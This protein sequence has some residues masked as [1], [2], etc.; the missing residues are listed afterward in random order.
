MRRP[1]AIA[2]VATRS[3]LYGAV[4][5]GL[6]AYLGMT[7]LPVF[8][9]VTAAALKPALAWD[10]TTVAYLIPTLTMIHNSDRLKIRQRAKAIDIQLWENITIIVL[11]GAF[12]LLAVGGVLERAKEV[13]GSDRIIH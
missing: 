4:L 6:L 13:Q 5:V 3:R 9:W 2:F 7:F 10:L 12:S 11:A 8:S 1:T